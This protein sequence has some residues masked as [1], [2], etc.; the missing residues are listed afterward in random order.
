MDRTERDRTDIFRVMNKEAFQSSKEDIRSRRFL[1]PRRVVWTGGQVENDE[2]LLEE[3][4]LQISLSAQNP[5]VLKNKD[6]KRASLLLDYGVEIHGGIRILAWADSTG[7]G[8]KVRIRFGESASEA[9]S[10]LGGEKNATNDHARRDLVAEVGMM[11]M[12]QIGETGFRFVRK[13]G[14]AHV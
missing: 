14:R 12:N 2:V 8:A 6:G 11:S 1:F 10:E 3:R 7:R 13:I 4:E 9:M 5:C